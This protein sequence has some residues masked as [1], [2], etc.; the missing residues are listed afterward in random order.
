MRNSIHFLFVWYILNVIKAVFMFK[1]NRLN[2]NDYDEFRN[3]FLDYFINDCG[4]NYDKEKLRENLV[5]KTILT[6]YEK[7]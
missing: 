2:K 1:I 6:Q 5:N 3:M 7:I 4:V